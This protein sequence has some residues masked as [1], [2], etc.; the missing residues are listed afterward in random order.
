MIPH[1]LVTQWAESNVKNRIRVCI[2]DVEWISV[3]L[4]LVSANM[5]VESKSNC[6]F[7]DKIDQWKRQQEIEA[8]IK[9]AEM[10]DAEL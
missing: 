3:V 5:N 10:E 2:L 4:T 9:E 6:A 8:D 1:R 7:P